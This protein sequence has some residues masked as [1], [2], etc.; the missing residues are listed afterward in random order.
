MNKQKLNKFLLGLSSAVLPLAFISA[1]CNTNQETKWNKLTKDYDFGLVHEPINSLNY[2]RYNAANRLLG[3][4]TE[5]IFRS[6]TNP[7]V[8]NV[9]TLPDTL[10]M[11][12]QSK[13]NTIE[14]YLASNSY[15]PKKASGVFF[16]LSK[17]VLPGSLT[18]DSSNDQVSLITTPSNNVLSSTI[19]LNRGA[20]KWSNG[21]PIEAADYI[22]YIHYILDINTGSQHIIR[23]SRSK[24]NE[25]NTVL[26]TQSDYINKY[27]KTYQNPFGY[28]P[29]IEVNGK[30]VYDVFNPKWKPWASQTAGDE[31]DVEAIK[32][33]VLSL[34]AYSNRLY[35][36]Y[37]NEEILQAI[38]FSPE[39]D[40]DA[41]ITVVMLPNPEYSTEKHTKE[42]LQNI[43]QRLATKIRKYHFT[44]PRQKLDR[45]K[46][47]FALNQASELKKKLTTSYDE[48]ATDL[49]AYNL[50]VSKLYG[51][52]DTTVPANYKPIDWVQ[53]RVFAL[54]EY[55]LRL[56][57]NPNE[58]QSLS[59]WVQFLLDQLFPVNRKFVEKVTTVA[60]FGLSEKEFLTS[61][62]FRISSLVLGGQGHIELEKDSSYYSADFTLS[63][64]IKIYF[65]SDPN[66][67]SALFD[68]GLISETKVPSIQQLNYWAQSDYRQF[69]VKGAGYG[70]IALAFNLDKETNGNSPL[71][72]RYLR[73]AIYYALNREEMLEIAGWNSS[74]PVITWTQFGSS[75]SSLGES[76]ESAFVN[77]WTN[78]EF[79]PENVDRSI[80]LQNYTHVDHLAKSYRFEQLP[81]RDLA[82]RKE[83]AQAYL[84]Q[85][86]KRHP[87]VKQV[88]LTYIT[89][90]T[91]EQTRVGDALVDQLKRSFKEEDANFFQI[92]IKPMPIT[93]YEDAKTSGKFDLLYGNFDIFGSDPYAYVIAFFTPDGIQKSQSKNSGFRNNPAGSWTYKQYFD[94]MGYSLNKENKVVNADV[95][96]DKALQERLNVKNE[97]I[98]KKALELAYQLPKETDLQYT[99]RLTAFFSN[100]FTNEEKALLFTEK[101]VFAVIAVFE[102][103]VRD[104]AV[105]VPLME[106]DTYWKISRV[107]GVT[108]GNTYSLQFA[109]DVTNPPQ[110]RL[111]R[112]IGGTE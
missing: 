74:F 43:P 60:K 26:K 15:E 27:K 111:P 85:Y 95:A 14:D 96:K 88:T 36:N 50:E 29:V 6:N 11:A 3:S 38:E 5:S 103:V 106:V 9:F 93:V 4:L 101:E 12:Y 21:D 44:D 94:E 89:N 25:V 59:P 80:P 67:N 52:R 47:L 86:K 82:Y 7:E 64:K 98:W 31:K 16:D 99:N 61:G 13:G 8:Q 81:R 34:G 56:E 102:K 100:Q 35:W 30:L 70:T 48:N 18:I 55:S 77:D 108:G 42:E 83:I 54:D 39:F 45:N 19:N 66:T 84:D 10:I 53:N 87:D 62:P 65:S 75:A 33:A 69:M 105:V 97:L 23:M 71:Q 63:N 72:D 20:S 57:F 24:I 78:V 109:Y 2:L 112:K 32:N 73:N 68:D 40:P 49:N 92:D 41:E 110:N 79:A 22:D 91:D 76:L 107:G 37:S 17:L 28:P 51:Q 90:S 46:L 58:P 1:S 104:S